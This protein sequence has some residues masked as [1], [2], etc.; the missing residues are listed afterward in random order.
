MLLQLKAHN[1]AKAHAHAKAGV[2]GAVNSVFTFNKSGVQSLV[3]ISLQ[4]QRNANGTYDPATIVFTDSSKNTVDIQLHLR[5][6]QQQ[7]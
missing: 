7:Q 5:Q 3:D 1:H 6:Q 2:A 4:R